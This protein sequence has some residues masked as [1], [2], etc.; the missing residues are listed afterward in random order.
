[1][2]ISFEH[3]SYIYSKGTPYEYQ[4]LKDVMLD[5]EEGKITAVIGQT[6]SG[7]STLVQHL[8]AL[9]LPEEGEI[10]ILDRVIRAGE[11]PKQLKSLRG[12][13]GLVFQ[14]PEYQ[15]FEETV[16]KDV[17]FGP[18]NFGIEENEAKKRAKKA[19]AMVGLSEKHYER[20]PLELSGGQKRRVA[21]A[22]IL[23]M[24]PEILVLDE[25]TAGLDPH[26][27]EAMMKLFYDLNH[28]HGK[29]ILIVTHDMEQ[30]FRYCD[31]VVVMEDGKVR[32]H[33]DA[34]SFFR[35]PAACRDMKILPPAL[36]RMKEM[37]KE[38]GFEI[39]DDILSE[40]ALAECIARQVKNHG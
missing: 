38:N 39:G 12:R 24:D 4:A 1:M 18:K 21:I 13:V 16:L 6:G 35:D 27:T 25:P 3:V 23:A 29:T 7:K 40:E 37:L 19:L 36:I 5:I 28:T 15:L 30:V 20:S 10:R 9:L 33:T 31:R 17:S 26:G 8:N 32:I 22:G 11:K 34:D 14:F 2:P